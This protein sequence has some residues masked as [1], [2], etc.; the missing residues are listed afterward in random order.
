[1][2]SRSFRRIVLCACAVVLSS[3]LVLFVVVVSRRV[4]KS[5]QDR[6]RRSIVEDV[7]RP[8]IQRRIQ[9]CTIPGFRSPPGPV[10]ALASFPGSG[11]TW[12]RFLVQQATGILTGSVYR[13]Y[14]LKRNGF[15]GEGV[16][17]GTVVLVKTHEWGPK[18]REP[19]DQALLLLRDPYGALMAEFNRR[20]AGHVGHAALNKFHIGDSW[21]RFVTTQSR[22][23]ME[24][25]MDWLQFGGPLL[26]MKYEVLATDLPG[27]LTRLLQFLGYH[28]SSSI[29]RKRLRC[30]LRN[31]D[32]LF[33]RPKRPL[34]FDPFTEEM[35]RTIDAYKQIVE[36]AIK[37]FHEN[38]TTTAIERHSSDAVS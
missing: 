3:Y 21:N 2:H 13:D 4:D 15:P 11:N 14:S 6:L 17:S 28:P 22:L 27:Q 1:M 30:V 33:R 12:I 36:D 7:R 38:T 32:G 9:V 25:A 19:F 20:A 5:A 23:W 35:R 18:A 29:S 26:V 10:T 34:P 31:R 37:E 16:C 24:S 8:R